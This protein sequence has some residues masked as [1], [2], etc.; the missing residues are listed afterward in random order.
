MKFISLIIL[1]FIIFINAN[2]AGFKTEKETK[3][4]SN[5]LVSQFIK[6][7]FKNALNKAKPYWPIPAVEIDG[8]LNKIN[9]QWPMVKQRFG[10]T[11]SME[12][13][14]TKRIGISFIRY[15]YLHKFE[16]HAIYWQLDYY[17]PINEWKINQITFLDTLN[18]LYE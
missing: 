6:D 13:V 14:Q 5:Q 18:T 11:T 17:K 3:F 7:D 1:S 12:L 2:A 8:M 16:N 4:F 10:S 15:I 9:Q